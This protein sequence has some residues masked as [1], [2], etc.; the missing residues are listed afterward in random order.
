ML[1]GALAKIATD[2]ANLAS[3]DVGEV[4]E[5]YTP[6]RGGSSA[7]PHKRNPVSATVTFLGEILA[8]Q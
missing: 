8:H 1:I 5:P 3:T 7:M 6:G 2:I 4:S